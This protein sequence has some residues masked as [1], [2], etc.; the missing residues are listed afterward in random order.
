MKK[1]IGH[2]ELKMGNDWNDHNA[3]QSQSVEADGEF[4]YTWFTVAEKIKLPK[5]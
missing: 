3:E 2:V 5:G 4:S 1:T